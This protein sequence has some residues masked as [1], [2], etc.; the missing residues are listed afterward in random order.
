VAIQLTAAELS[1][2]IGAWLWPF[3]RLAAL[4][5][6]APLIGGAYVPARVRLALAVALALVVAPLVP[7]PPVDPLS[8]GGALLAG[9]QVLIG[10][11]LGFA[12]RLVLAVFDLAG[13][14]LSQTM[15]LGF[16]SMVDPATGT[17]VPAVSQLY[18][19]LTS[20]VFV[21]VDGHL[22]LVRVLVRSFEVLPLAGE[23]PGAGAVWAVVSRAGWVFGAGVVVA[24]PAVTAML[25][26]N[27][28]LAVMT[29]AAPQLNVFAV[30]FPITLLVGFTVMLVALPGTLSHA[31]DL[32]RE[33]L[34]FSAGVL[35]GG[36]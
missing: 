18:L 3:F 17:Q 10:L 20:L 16:A 33:A 9:Q 5:T 26:V 4:L 2:L 19:V 13:Q 36:P 1:S 21:A 12:A 24:L 15:G 31:G 7:V 23:G 29:R 32:V 8:A 6:A 14:L 28:A 27:L 35:D 11:L 22:M 30:G 34:E 25:L